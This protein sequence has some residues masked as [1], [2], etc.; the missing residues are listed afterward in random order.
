[1][2][3]RE[4]VK[5]SGLGDV[6]RA[7]RKKQQELINAAMHGLKLASLHYIARAKAICPVDTGNLV[8]SLAF[9]G[10]KQGAGYLYAQISAK[11]VSGKD[12]SVH[13]NYAYKVHENMVYDGPRV[14][15]SGTQN[16][17]PKTLAKGISAIDQSDGTAG[18]KYMERPL[19]N[20]TD[21]YRKLIFDAIGKAMSVSGVKY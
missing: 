18:G 20:N 2:D 17:G 15:G 9:N 1:M 11:A 16:R 12:E 13:I 21:V 7:L 19:R 14:G 8:N 5:V 3:P 4:L 10:I 6:L